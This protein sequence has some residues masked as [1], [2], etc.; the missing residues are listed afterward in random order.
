MSERKYIKRQ[1]VYKG[2]IILLLLA[3]GVFQNEAN[4]Q[5]KSDSSKTKITIDPATVNLDST[6]TFKNDSLSLL[7]KIIQ[8][9]K[10]RQNRNNSELNRVYQF[11]MGLVKKGELH[12]DSSTVNDI[13][14]QL[15]TISSLNLANAQ[16]IDTIIAKN[17]LYQKASKV[18]IDSI[19]TQIKEVFKVIEDNNK[20]SNDKPEDLNINDNYLK[21][22]RNVQSS[23]YVGTEELDSIKTGDAWDYFYKRLT[24]KTNIIG[25]HYSWNKTEYLNYNYN[26]LSAINLYGYEISSNGKVRNPGDIK[27]FEKAGG[28]IELAQKNKCDVHLTI[29]SKRPYDITRL[30]NSSSAQN[31]MMSDL[32]TLISRDKLKGINVYF[33][34]I[35]P[36]DTKAFVQFITKLHQNLTGINDSIQLNLTIPAVEDDASLTKI[37]V[38]DFPGLNP[39]IDHYMV[40]TDR[41]TSLQNNKALTASP[42]YNSDSYGQRTI[43]STVNFYSNGKI[44]LSKIIVSL[45]YEGIQWP[46]DD[47]LGTVEEGKSGKAIIYS[48]IIDQYK[49]TQVAG[50]TVMGGFDSIQVAAYLNISDLDAYKTGQIPRTQVWYEDANSLLLKYNWIMQNNLGGVAIRGL[51][52]DDG[53]SELWDVLGTTLVQID[54]VYINKQSNEICPCEYDS[55]E[56]ISA[57]LKLSNWKALWSDFL[58]AK[59]QTQ[60]SSYFSLFSDDYNW[61]KMAELKYFSGI[62]KHDKMILKNEKVCRDLICRWYIYSRILFGFTLFFLVLAAIVIFWRNQLERFK[63]GNDNAQLILVIALWLFILLALLTLL[64]GLFFEPSLDSIGAGNQGES[65]FWILVKTAVIGIILGILLKISLNKNKYKLKKQP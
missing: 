5:T 47:F 40:L 38:Y 28:V 31:T 10:F 58:E 9:F 13:M 55:L 60:D 16:S 57:E 62:T 27:E 19:T 30:L 11:M 18:V 23:L 41:L 63:L 50:R 42:L 24:P 43:E 17:N 49:N 6:L 2:L 32:D 33:E 39:L 36:K 65:N 46:V 48:K 14:I 7:Q 56:N 51:G 25:W 4:G 35:Y 54:T 26:Y 44:P 37:S 61:A 21:E 53:Y 29:Y 34:G 59:N 20:K 1:H 3:G 15:D 64:L 52:Y 8:P 12:I 22:I 45:S